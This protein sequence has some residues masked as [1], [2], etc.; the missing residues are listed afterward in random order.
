MVD[1]GIFFVLLFLLFVLSRLFTQELSLVLYRFTRSE[2]WVVT[3]MAILFL[4]GT[5]IH[6]LSHYVTA[7]LLGVPAGKM[8][9]TPEVRGNTVKMGSVSIAET[10]M[11]RRFLIGIAP[12]VWG[13]FFILALM[14]I[15]SSSSYAMSPLVLVFVLL[16]TFVVGNTMYSSKRDM[17]G[18][19]GIFI[20]LAIVFIFFASVI[21]FS[22][23][24]LSDIPVSFIDVEPISA[25]FSMGWKFLLVP[26]G[27]D[28][29]FITM[30][31]IFLKR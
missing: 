11:F 13:T 7:I 16:L 20:F 10:D 19:I 24:S 4:P 26:I 29:I 6:E 15:A 27:I 2:K 14:F 12:V 18:A 3:I 22:S 17:E 30:F 5:F 9:F 8:E 23:I 31:Y 28:L 25:A 21:Y 1:V